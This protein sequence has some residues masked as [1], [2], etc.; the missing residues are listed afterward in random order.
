M[1]SDHENSLCLALAG[2]TIALWEW[3]VTD[4]RVRWVNDWCELADS[5]AR[6]PHVARLQWSDRLH[7]ADKRATY[8][9]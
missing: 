2:T 9:P 5:S 6:Q 3:D 4:D 7:P 8:A 1:A